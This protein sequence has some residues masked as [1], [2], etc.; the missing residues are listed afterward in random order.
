MDGMSPAMFG[1]EDADTYGATK[2]N[3]DQALQVL[4]MPYSQA[5]LA[6][7][8]AAE[9]AVQCAAQNRVAGIQSSIPGQDKLEIEISKLQ[10]NALCYPESME[11]P[12]TI[13]E[14][15]A[16]M[17]ELL[18]NGKNVQLY[19]AITNDPRNL[20]H[21]AKFP[22][23][24]GLEIPGLDAVEEQ[25]GE[26]DLLMQSGPQ[27]NPQLAQ[28][29]QQLQA[30]TSQLQQGVTHPE[31]QTPEGQ[32]AMQALQQQAQQL[33]QQMQSLPPQVSSVQVAQNGSQNHAIH[34]AITLGM[35][36]SAEGRKLKNGTPEQQAIFQNLE[37]HW[38]EHEQMKAKLTP[39]PPIDAKFSVSAAIDKAPPEVQAQAWAALGVQAQP[40][41]WE[42]A[43]QLVPH[44]VVT[45][46]EGVDAQGVPVRQKISMVG[47]GLN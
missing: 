37:L 28:M 12:Q 10:G 39:V 23:L 3:R 15:E 24:A 36:N 4:S 21:M 14:Q 8:K 11:I 9:Q 44:E 22:S 43:D 20:T 2:L 45:E 29:Q 33:Q 17:A 27:P 5:T 46:K 16:Q 18:E 40:A 47:K 26:F 7:A 35:M 34:S 38:Q 13:A 30:I 42:S 31:A 19:A 6:F 41:D 1:M 25:Q 32:Q